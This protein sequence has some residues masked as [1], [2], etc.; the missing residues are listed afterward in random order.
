MIYKITLP[1]RTLPIF[2]KTLAA[3]CRL[4]EVK[5][6]VNYPVL[7]QAKEYPY[8]SRHN[9]TVDKVDIS[10]ETNTVWAIVKKQKTT[11]FANALSLLVFLN[12]TGQT[13]KI[14]ELL[15]FISDID[16]HAPDFSIN[17]KDVQIFATT[18]IK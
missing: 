14:L 16:L 6:R 18:V 3:A 15:S 10:P 11:Y 5:S 1:G 9:V 7:A 13:K 12:D 8:T 17:I 4:D 2:A